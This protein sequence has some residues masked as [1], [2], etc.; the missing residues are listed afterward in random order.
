MLVIVD[1]AIEK[2]FLL[3]KDIVLEL[4]KHVVIKFNP[5]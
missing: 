5:N 1:I 4:V 2:D 3:K